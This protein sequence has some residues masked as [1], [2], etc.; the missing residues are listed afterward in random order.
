MTGATSMAKV[1]ILIGSARK[2]GNSAVL[3]EHAADAARASGATTETVFL[4]DLDIRP[5]TGCS[6]CRESV[7]TPCVLDDGMTALYPRLKAA[8]AVLIATPIYSYDMAAQTKLLIDRLY[9]LGGA[10]GNALAGKRFGFIVVYG[11]SDPETSGAETAMRCLRATFTR[12][13]TWMNI[14]HGCAYR[15]G[16]AAKNETLM[17]DAAALG[18]GLAGT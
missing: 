13:A 6:T 2:T 10:D 11:G 1:L 7:D 17:A 8:D 14:V 15:I 9:A 12:K 4:G 3:A 16:D 18:A 5:C